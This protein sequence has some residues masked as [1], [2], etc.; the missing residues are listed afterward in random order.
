MSR[1]WRGAHPFA[2][3]RPPQLG[4]ATG[5]GTAASSRST[6]AAQSIVPTSAKA[7]LIARSSDP[8]SACSLVR[9]TSTGTVHSIVEPLRLLAF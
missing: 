8:T 1:S 7:V 5:R 2:T 3:K 6:S 4:Q 9:W